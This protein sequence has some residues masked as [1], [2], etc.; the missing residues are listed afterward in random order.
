M[1]RYYREKIQEVETLVTKL[2]KESVRYSW[3]RA[4]IV[5]A[6]I[7]AIWIGI[8][9][10]VAGMLVGGIL[11]IVFFVLIHLHN[12]VESEIVRLKNLIAVY[13]NELSIREKNLFGTG[14]EYAD[15]THNYAADLDVFGSHSLF[16]YLNR[17]VTKEGKDT[18]AAFLL[19]RTTASDIEERQQLSI[20]LS[21]KQTFKERFLSTVF[22]SKS[23]DEESRKIYD[24]IDGFVSFFQSKHWLLILSYAL[25]I[26]FTASIGLSFLNVAW[27]GIA[28]GI[29]ILNCFITSA[30]NSRIGK[31]HSYIGNKGHLFLK[32]S[33][34]MNFIKAE[35]FTHPKLDD[36]RNDLIYQHQFDRK[37]QRIAF[38]TRML[39]CRD[40]SIVWFFLNGIS[41]WDIHCAFA[42]EKWFI[43][44]RTELAPCLQEIGK[45]D[46]YLTLGIFRFNHPTWVFPTIVPGYFC[47]EAVQMAHPLIPEQ[48]RVSNNFNMNPNDKI[49]IITGSNMSGKSTFLRTLGV[50]MV[51]AYAGMPVCADSFSVSLAD[52]QTYMRTRDSLSEN[53]SSFRA[54]LLRLKKIIDEIERNPNCFL[55]LDELLKG[56]NS[57]DKYLGSV[58]IVKHFLDR[59]TAGLVATHDLALTELQQQYPGSISNYHFDITVD[60]EE[61]FF[62]YKLCEGVCKTFN[63]QLLLKKIGIEIYKGQK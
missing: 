50:N 26:C 27:S 61:L 14:I 51:L 40:S 36:I 60:G 57:T 17:T 47:I 13:E 46:A 41:L 44:N 22:L 23:T 15:D 25:P 54:E 31:I 1:G 56:T 42:I 16:A 55:L 52:I 33:R 12:K 62:D 6:G 37:L 48:T 21:E 9:S 39:D 43:R 24:F 53:T 19:K 38:L 29:F 30:Y 8:L 10:F 28:I 32:Y 11:L 58:A 4:I 34:L 5:L 35:L 59:N 20:E 63:A 49:G 3:I 45:M 18:L 2:Q 7:L